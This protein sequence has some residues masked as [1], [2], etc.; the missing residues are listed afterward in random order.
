MY[1]WVSLIYQSGEE[2]KELLNEFLAEIHSEM[3]SGLD[4]SD[5]DEIT[6]E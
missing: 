6:P 1:K 3:D 5:L 2:L 4:L